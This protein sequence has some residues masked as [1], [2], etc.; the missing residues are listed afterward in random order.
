M[1]AVA[2]ILVLA[3][4]LFS[5]LSLRSLFREPPRIEKISWKTKF[6]YY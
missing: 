3:M 5:S 1:E 6:K 4:A 2:Y